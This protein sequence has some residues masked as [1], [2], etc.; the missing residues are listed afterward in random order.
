MLTKE[1][2]TGDAEGLAADRSVT[3]GD[4]H[5]ESTTPRGVLPHAQKRFREN[6]GRVTVP[7]TKLSTVHGVKS[8]G[9]VNNNIYLL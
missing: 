7:F 5:K 6:F 4:T 9:F 8:V 1:R 3:C 2:A